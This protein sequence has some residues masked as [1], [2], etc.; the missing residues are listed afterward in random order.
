MRYITEAERKLA[1]QCVLH[2][3]VTWSRHCMWA[4]SVVWVQEI[5]QMAVFSTVC[6]II[7][8]TPVNLKSCLIVYKPIYDNVSSSKA[9]WESVEDWRFAS[10]ALKYKCVIQFRLNVRIAK[11]LLFI[12]SVTSFNVGQITR[13]NDIC[14]YICTCTVGTLQYRLNCPPI[15]NISIY[16]GT[17]ELFSILCELRLNLVI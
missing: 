3:Y 5:Q 15:L 7:D 12:V 2:R 11:S 14:T 17:I 4:F 13:V 10:W 1:R 8:V 16:K 9:C 6:R